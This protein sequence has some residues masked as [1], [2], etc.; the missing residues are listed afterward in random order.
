MI[1]RLL[2]CWWVRWSTARQ[3][4]VRAT[5]TTT[6]TFHPSSVTDTIPTSTADTKG[7]GKF[8]W[9]T[10]ASTG[11]RMTQFT[12]KWAHFLFRRLIIT[13][14]NTFRLE[15]IMFLTGTASIST[16]HWIRFKQILM[17]CF[18]FLLR[19]NARHNLLNTKNVIVYCINGITNIKLL[20]KSSNQS[21]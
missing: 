6:P 4:L 21:N 12:T 3:P 9:T 20:V 13:V 10:A 18:C 5:I 17:N 19:G 14:M 2:W 7:T 1:F 16:S 8:R 11:V 15:P